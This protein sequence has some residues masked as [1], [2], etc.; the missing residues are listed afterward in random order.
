MKFFT[1]V[2]SVAFIVKGNSYHGPPI[3]VQ[4]NFHVSDGA[5]DKMQRHNE[6]PR[7]Y[8]NSNG[9]IDFHTTTTTTA[10]PSSTQSTKYK[11]VWFFTES[12]TT[13]KP[14]EVLKNHEQHIYKPTF[15]P[16]VL[17]AEISN[18][19]ITTSTPTTPLD[20]PN[21]IETNA[22][23]TAVE[24]VFDLTET[25]NRL[26]SNSVLNISVVFGLPMVTALLSFLGAGPIAIASAA[27]IIPLLTL[28]I[29]PDLLRLED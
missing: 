8:L 10:I 6:R 16:P 20:A 21:E 5:S 28:L 11:P 18:V 26:S 22:S 13:S 24:K 15:R 4:A 3:K 19:A 23:S 1:V 2:F 27:W 12:T 17:M 25:F 14:E 9:Q 7:P 29:V